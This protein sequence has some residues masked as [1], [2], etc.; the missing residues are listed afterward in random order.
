[1]SQSASCQR[2]RVVFHQV[3]SRSGGLAEWGGGVG[4]FRA[5]DRQTDRRERPAAPRG[6]TERRGGCVNKRV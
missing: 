5:A 2:W 3:L 1:M 4:A 6:V